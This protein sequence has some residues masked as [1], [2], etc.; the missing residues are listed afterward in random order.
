MAAA[1]T[2]LPP[3]E[4]PHSRP[5]TLTSYFNTQELLGIRIAQAA[6]VSLGDPLSLLAAPKP[7][8]AAGAGNPGSGQQTASKDTGRM[9]PQ[10]HG[11]MPTW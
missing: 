5:F 8:A 7:F 9:P 1:P 6:S 11:S 2:L 10:S 4:P 3:P